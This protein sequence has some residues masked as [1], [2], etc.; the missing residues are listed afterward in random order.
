MDAYATHQSALIKTVLE[1]DGDILE[2]GCG[3]YSTPILSLIAKHQN[4]KFFI[5][6][7]DTEWSKKFIDIADIEI[8]DWSTWEP[9]GSYGVIFLDNE[10]L[11]S[12]RIK[13]LPTLSKIA[14]VIV[15]HDVDA[16]MLAPDYQKLT[17]GFKELSLHAI[18][19]PWT[20]VYKC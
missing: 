11:T 10:Q 3:D 2:L 6:S 4:K 14:K 8:V 15:M 1:T 20:A 19:S 16:A 18:Y 5:K 13:W 9:Q 7:S 12:E 17:E